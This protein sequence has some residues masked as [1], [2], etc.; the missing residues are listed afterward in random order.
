MYSTK[1]FVYFKSLVL[2][3]P[4]V[5]RK[6]QVIFYSDFEYIKILNLSNVVLQKLSALVLYVEPF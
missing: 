6:E 4:A 2:S 3:I 5:L 1:L